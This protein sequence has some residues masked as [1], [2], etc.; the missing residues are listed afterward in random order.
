MKKEFIQKHFIYFMLYAILGWIYEVFLE[1]VV[2]RWGFS[3]R[4][5]LFGPYCPVYGFGAIINGEDRASMCFNINFKEDPNIQYVDNIIKE[6]H[7]CLRKITFSGPTC[8]A[9][10]I[11]KIIISSIYYFFYIIILIC[12][13]Q[14][15]CFH[16]TFIIVF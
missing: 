6:Y 11:N 13:K 16:I 12:S 8:F 1:V 15:F 3:N 5:V 10:I 4:G 14:F 2:Y 9:P 7:K